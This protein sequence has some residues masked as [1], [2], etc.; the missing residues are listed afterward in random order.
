MLETSAPYRLRPVL[1][2]W[3][4]S[5]GVLRLVVLLQTNPFETLLLLGA[6]SH[7]VKRVARLAEED[8][9]RIFECEVQVFIN[10][11]LKKSAQK[12]TSNMKEQN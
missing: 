8:L 9:S 7:N 1:D 12:K 11:H 4:F 2:S 6:R 3:N 10:V 5:D